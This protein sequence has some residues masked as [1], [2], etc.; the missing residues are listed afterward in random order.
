MK[1]VWHLIDARGQIVGRLASQ[2][3]TLLRGKHKPTYC[4]N[5]DCGDYVVIINAADVKFTGRKV[6][7]KMYRWHTGY[8]GGLKEMNVKTLLQKKPEEVCF[9]SFLLFQ[10]S[11]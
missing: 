2:I 4:P 5:Y 8:V 7:D 11:P 3:T 10:I 6:D 9:L 1:P